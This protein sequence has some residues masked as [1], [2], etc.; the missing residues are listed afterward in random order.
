MQRVRGNVLAI[1]V[2]ILRNTDKGSRNDQWARIVHVQ[3]GKILHTGQINYIKRVAKNKYN[4][5]TS[6]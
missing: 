1:P 2:K 5:Q 4:L 6:L 3:T